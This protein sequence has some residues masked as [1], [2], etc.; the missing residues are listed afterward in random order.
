M[1]K[2]KKLNRAVALILALVMSVSCF[3]VTALAANAHATDTMSPQV[4]VK[5]VGSK[6]FYKIVTEELTQTENIST[7]EYEDTN[8]VGDVKITQVPIADNIKVSGYKN[9][10]ASLD[11][12]LKSSIGGQGIDG[13]ILYVQDS[14]MNKTTIGTTDGSMSVDDMDSLTFSNISLNSGSFESDSNTKLDYSLCFI[15]FTAMSS[16]TGSAISDG[17]KIDITASITVTGEKVIGETTSVTFADTD[18]GSGW[19]AVPSAYI[20]GSEYNV[21][22]IAYG[23]YVVNDKVHFVALTDCIQDGD[24]NYFYVHGTEESAA[25][26]IDVDETSEG[27]NQIGTEFWL[28]VEKGLSPDGPSVDITTDGAT[29]DERI[30][31]EIVSKVKTNYQLD[32]TV[33][34]YVCMYG[35]AGDG[36]VVTP[37]SDSYKLKNYSTITQGKTATI[38]DIVKLTTMTKIIDTEHSDENLAAI[39]YNAETGAYMWWYS[40]P[41]DEEFATFTDWTINKDIADEN[42]NASGECY[43]IYVDDTW[44]FKTSGVLDNGVLRQTVTAVEDAHPLKENFTFNGFDFA[45]KTPSVGLSANG[46]SAK[47]GLAVKITELQALP[48]TWKLVPVSTGVSEIKRGELAMSIAPAKAIQDASA[49]DL[50]AC[51]APID[52]TNRGWYLG[53]PTIT[54]AA[55]NT[56]T[57]TPT[58]LPLITSA[59]MAGGNVNARG[60]TSVVKVIYTVTPMFAIDDGQTETV[61]ADAVESNLLPTA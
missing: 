8:V 56:E 28:R 13:G 38:T 25:V 33:P 24:G 19:T 21:G 34:M 35:Y 41:T 1:I 30:N 43:V 20:S 54:V 11:L 42:L 59:R 36:E 49:V 9:V 17:T 15:N 46:T 45:T 47:E 23:A 37:T 18:D 57:I 14:K 60:C 4:A 27:D 10:T 5:A 61:E 7:K 53:K 51:S 32:A 39:A 58:E 31:Y 52:I 29:A 55:D 26:S 2:A 44:T 22:N 50:A 6:A 48:A 3:C 12:T 40:M 16:A